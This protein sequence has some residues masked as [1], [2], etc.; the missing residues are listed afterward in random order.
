MAL[1]GFMTSVDH[2]ASAEASALP[3]PKSLARALGPAAVVVA[4][5]SALATFLV[6][7]GLTPIA[8]THTVVVT[9]LLGN[10]V[11]VLLLLGI[12]G[13]ELWQ[14]VQARRTGR[15][16]ARLHVRIIAL[17]SIIAAAPAILVSIVAS[18]TLDRGLDRFFSERT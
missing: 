7:A 6:L 11:A 1:R 2:V 17:F 4:L 9:L 12:I 16:G 3:S 5:L 18:I 13:R 8:P 14:I 10:A 15:A